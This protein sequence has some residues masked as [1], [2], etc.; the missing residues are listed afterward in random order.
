MKKVILIL[1]VLGTLSLASC[2]K[3]Y[4]CTCTQ[5]SSYTAAT[6]AGGAADATDIALINAANST[7]YYNLH[8]DGV[9]T[10]TTSE[11][12][13]K[14]SE[15]AVCASSVNTTVSYVKDSPDY[16]S[17]GNTN[18]VAYTSTSTTTNDCSAKKK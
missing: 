2:K 1:T 11:K 18:E 15:N 10:V 16:D 12:T 9:T 4:E 6:T 13:S 14:A 5:T 7:N 17:D 3:A 8:P